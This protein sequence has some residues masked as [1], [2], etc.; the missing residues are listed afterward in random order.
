M[1][2]PT[3]SKNTKIKSLKL[4]GI[5]P[6]ISGILIIGVLAVISGVAYQWG[7]PIMQKNVG[8]TQLHSSEDFARMLDKKIDDVAKSGGSDELTFSIPGQITIKPLEDRIDFTVE[9]SGSIYSSGGFVCFSRNCDLNSGIWGVDGYSVIG[10]QVS[11]SDQNYALTKYSIIFRN[12]TADKLT[13][14]RD[15]VT[16][17]NATLTGSEN[18]KLTI[19][20]I[21]EV[22]GN[23]TTTII[24]ID[25]L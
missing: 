5:E 16:P 3:K 11:T 17:R 14:S 21:G 2:K 20:K 22:R 1:L 4:K 12:L 15:L 7:M 6:V 25:L 8:T 18:S 13:Y 19:T 9:T 23:T 24:K 10:A